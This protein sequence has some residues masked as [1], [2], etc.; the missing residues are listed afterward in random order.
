MAWDEDR[1]RAPSASKVND[2]ENV[3]K[4]RFPSGSGNEGTARIAA[5][6]SGDTSPQAGRDRLRVAD[7]RDNPEADRLLE[8]VENGNDFNGT[9][10]PV[11]RIALGLHQSAKAKAE[12][13]RRRLGPQDA[14]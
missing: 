3:S 9:V 10:R 2:P 5:G 12:E 7:F 4:K 6:L 8:Q 14:A 1:R 13:A 11:Q